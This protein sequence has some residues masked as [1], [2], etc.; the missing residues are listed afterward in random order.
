MKGMPSD[1][2]YA[3]GSPNFDERTGTRRGDI[4]LQPIKQAPIRVPPVTGGP[5]PPFT[6]GR[7]GM[8]PGQT[9]F[10]R[11]GGDLPPPNTDGGMR[12]AIFIDENNNGI[13][14]R[15]EGPGMGNGLFDP[16]GYGSYDNLM[17][18]A[19]AEYSSGESP[20]AGA[21]DFLMNRPV[22]D[23]GA[24]PESSMGFGG[25][26]PSFGYSNAGGFGSL[27]QMQNQ[28]A[29]MQ[30]QYDQFTQ[31]LQSAQEAAQQQAQERSDM[32]AS[33]RQALMDRIAALEGRE[34]PDLE[35]FRQ[36]ILS[37][38]P[39]QQEIDIEALRRQIMGE[40]ETQLQQ[41][42][43]DVERI[44]D[45]IMS[46]LTQE[47]QVEIERLRQMIQEA[48]DAGA[49][50]EE[51]NA[52]RSELQARIQPV[53]E[54][55]TTIEQTGQPSMEEVLR[56]VDERFNT[57]D[58]ARQIQE[59]RDR[60][61]QGGGFDMEDMRRQI[62]E[63]MDARQIDTGDI[64]RRLREQF[65]RRYQT[66]DFDPDAIRRQ[67]QEMRDRL[68]QRPEDRG[69]V[70]PDVLERLR[71]VEGRRGS[72]INDLRERIRA[73]QERF[74]QGS[75]PVYAGGSPNFDERTGRPVVT[76]PSGP[77]FDPSR[78]GSGG[79]SP[80]L[81]PIGRTGGDLPP[82]N[83]TGGIKPQPAPSKIRD[84]LVTRPRNPI[85]PA[86]GR[87]GAVMPPMMGRRGRG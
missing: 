64:E 9:P 15:D 84:E 78:L 53:E 69:F 5:M 19:F 2:V 65:D 27:G 20:Y 87:M 66:P 56:S 75:A 80:G 52:L 82:P 18:R 67:I 14:D 77:T 8:S 46:Q 58:I 34:Q 33:E 16:P 13:D 31:Q 57:D 10:G 71:A 17:N 60:F 63:A 29:G 1:R 73:M 47:E 68:N 85:A 86:P 54:R 23:R 28:Q 21:A 83:R 44:R 25:G 81:T 55:L 30:Q 49:S 51:I 7:G 42:L 62:R 26:M 50:P 74:N 43:P 38:I 70:P 24:R 59:L 41:N 76:T 4:K 35:A 72:D 39:E 11:T 3:G 48:V 61:G 12:T 40:V 6:P 79:V 36:D 45:E 32:A 37:Q 22:F